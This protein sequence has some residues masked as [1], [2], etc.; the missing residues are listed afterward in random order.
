MDTGG[1]SAADL[2]K[3]HAGS[4]DQNPAACADRAPFLRVGCTLLAFG[5]NVF[6]QRAFRRAQLIARADL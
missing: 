4:S 6:R 1:A 3:F 2:G 5:R